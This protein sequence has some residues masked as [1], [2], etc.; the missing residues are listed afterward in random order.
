MGHRLWSLH[1]RDRKVHFTPGIL[2]NTF[3]KEYTSIRTHQSPEP[4]VEKKVSLFLSY[5][6]IFSILKLYK[7]AFLMFYI[8]SQNGP[9]PA[10]TFR[11]DDYALFCLYHLFWM[12]SFSL[13]LSAFSSA[14]INFSIKSQEPILSKSPI[15]PLLV[16]TLT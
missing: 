12:S 13:N 9:V 11:P 2:K 6:I 3:R 1:Q 14:F 4:E 15:S 5:C 10:Q 16:T 7:Q 8:A